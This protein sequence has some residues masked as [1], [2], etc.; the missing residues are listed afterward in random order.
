MATEIDDE[1]IEMLLTLV[2]SEVAEMMVAFHDAY[3]KT[4]EEWASE[5]RYVGMDDPAEQITSEQE[6]NQSMPGGWH[7]IDERLPAGW[8]V[9]EGG[10]PPRPRKRWR[11][12]ERP[13]TD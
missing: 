1:Q 12:K 4:W 13:K 10:T 11:G 6:L 5:F 9:I 3:A 7:I 8:E 2:K